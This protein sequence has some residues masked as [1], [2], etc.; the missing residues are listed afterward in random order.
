MSVPLKKVLA[1]MSPERR[2]RVKADAARMIAEEMTL[3]DLRKALEMTQEKL[4]HELGVKQ[5]SVSNLEKRSDMLIS[6]LREYVEALGG[7]LEIRATFPGR[8][9]VSIKSLAEVSND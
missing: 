5:V 3:R 4:A 8:P 1:K 9:P 2:A 6:T 7:E